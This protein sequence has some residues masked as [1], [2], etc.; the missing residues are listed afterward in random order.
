[1]IA[2]VDRPSMTGDPA[3]VRELGPDELGD[4]DART[5]DVPGGEVYQSRAFGAYRSRHGWR[6][7]Y[8][9]LGDGG[10]VLALERSWPLV[11][12]GGAYLPRG[13]VTGGDAP[14]VTAARLI[15]AARWL[16]AQG[17]DVVSADPAVPV[18]SAYPDRIAAA[19]FRPIEEI[20]PSRHRMAVALPAAASEDDLLRACDETTRRHIRGALK[21][22]VRCVRYDALAGGDPGEGFEAPDPADLSSAGADVMSRLYDVLAETG[23]RRGFRVG[24]RGPFLD[25]GRTGLEAGRVVVLEML[26]PDGRTLAAAMF[27]RHGGRLTYSHSGDRGELR[28]A[29]PGVA[30]LELWRALQLAHREGLGEF[31]LGGVDVPGARRIPVDGEPMWGLYRFKRSFGAHWVEQAGNHEWVARPWR[32]AAGRLTARLVGGKGGPRRGEDRPR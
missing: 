25:W 30:H 1:V 9:A 21:R 16:A 19:G 7:R 12:G 32:Y 26:D 22:G 28:R 2:A 31:D 20:Q 6:A 24:A 13:P 10:R 3:E 27:Y 18:P 8:L 17:L 23:G 4:W 15:A 29:W 14:E 11:G 5:V